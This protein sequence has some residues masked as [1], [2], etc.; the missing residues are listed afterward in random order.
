M[1][2]PYSNFRF[3]QIEDISLICSALNIYAG[4]LYLSG[5]IGEETK[6]IFFTVMLLATIIFLIMF[7]N[8][9][10]REAHWLQSFSLTKS[11]IS[12]DPVL[13]YFPNNEDEYS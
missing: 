2:K 10:M 6:I 12:C 8:A 9:Y 11:Y 13:P 5:D 1:F 4:T 7:I 3:N